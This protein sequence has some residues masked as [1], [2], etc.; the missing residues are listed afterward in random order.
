MTYG[1]Y[2]EKGG[3]PVAGARTDE[4]YNGLLVLKKTAERHSLSLFIP[5]LEFGDSSD[6][7]ARWNVSR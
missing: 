1:Y 5:N 3:S 2:A 7:L 4:D 6:I